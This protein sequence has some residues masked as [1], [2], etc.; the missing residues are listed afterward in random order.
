MSISFLNKNKNDSSIGN[1][2][3]YSTDEVKTNDVWINGKPIYRKVIE[4]STLN[5]NATNNIIH[6]IENLNKIVSISGMFIR[7]DGNSE[8]LPRFDVATSWSVIIGDINNTSISTIV[9]SSY[10]GNFSIS[11]GHF[12]MEYTKTT[13]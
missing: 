1:G 12:I 3:N 6:N 2:I 7:V 8:I 5:P 13:D 11:S 9:G 4:F 10:S